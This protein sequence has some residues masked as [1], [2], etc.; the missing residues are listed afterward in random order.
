VGVFANLL[1]IPFQVVIIFDSCCSTQSNP[2]ST[3]MSGNKLDL[4][5]FI[6]A[7][8]AAVIAGVFLLLPLH[9]MKR[10]QIA[11]PVKLYP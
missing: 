5:P 6:A 10:R 2:L 4:L 11:D 1:K 7:T 3:F 9:L 8:G